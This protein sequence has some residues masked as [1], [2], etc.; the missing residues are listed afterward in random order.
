M[1]LNEETATTAGFAGLCF[2][3]LRGML[4]FLMRKFD[5][6]RPSKESE[7]VSHYHL[8]DKAIGLLA[9]SME[10][11]TELLQQ[12]HKTQ[13][14]NSNAIARLEAKIDARWQTKL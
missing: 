12:I 5:S 7:G 2:L 13:S 3:M 14:D 8:L 1:T 6:E 11:Q 4:G 10:N 9:Q